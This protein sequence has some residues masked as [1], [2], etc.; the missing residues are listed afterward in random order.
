MAWAGGVPL[1]H[2]GVN[3]G[4]LL[5]AEGLPPAAGEV[6][7]NRNLAASLQLVADKGKAGFYQGQVADAIVEAVQREGGVLTHEVRVSY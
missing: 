6:F 7:V 4:E 3:G 5:N 2:R 1:L